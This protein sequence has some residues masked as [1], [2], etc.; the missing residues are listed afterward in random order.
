MQNDLNKEL[1]KILSFYNSVNDI[2]RVKKLSNIQL[3][4]ELLFYDELSIIKN[5]TAFSGYSRSYKVEIVDKKDMII[6]LKSSEIVIKD[7]FKNLLLELKG[8]KYQLTLNIL[9]SKQKSS[10]EI[11]YRSVYF[12]SL[13]KT[14]IGN[15]YFLEDCFQEIIKYIKLDFTWL[16]M[17]S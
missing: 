5:K 3:L 4:K 12:N 17:E 11:E 14:V 2:P 7:L 13:T 16:W 1:L 6:Q 10:N 9:L 8:F 15:N